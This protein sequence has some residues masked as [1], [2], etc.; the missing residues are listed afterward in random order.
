MHQIAKRG[1]TEKQSRNSENLSKRTSSLEESQRE[2]IHVQ[3]TI[4]LC[5]YAVTGTFRLE[6]SMCSTDI[7]SHAESSRGRAPKHTDY[8]FDEQPNESA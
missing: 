1:C 5:C 8:E 3:G 2:D 6:L 7:F 4:E